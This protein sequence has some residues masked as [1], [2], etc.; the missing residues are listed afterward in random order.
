MVPASSSDS[1]ICTP[2]AIIAM[3]KILQRSWATTESISPGAVE[4]RMAPTTARRRCTGTATETT[5]WLCSSTR[6][7][8]AGAPCSADATSG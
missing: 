1:A 6:T 3:R 2:A 7:K 4:S 5:S 8:S